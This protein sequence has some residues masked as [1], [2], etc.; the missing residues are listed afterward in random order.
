[1]SNPIQVGRS[2]HWPGGDGSEPSAL[3]G[4]M[5]P[6]RIATENC[7]SSNLA[8][9][10][11][12]IKI[13]HENSAWFK[14]DVFRVTLRTLIGPAFERVHVVHSFLAWSLSSARKV[15][16]PRAPA[17][18]GV[19]HPSTV[20]WDSFPPGGGA[21]SADTAGGSGRTGATPSSPHPGTAAGRS[22]S[23]V[24]C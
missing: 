11:W 22:S 15:C 23:A 18:A 19:A 7:R 6:E 16:T 4:D 2:D 5:V 10:R 14:S 21:R 9:A 24:G 8:D 17:S 12:P 13:P 1:M 20:P 3:R